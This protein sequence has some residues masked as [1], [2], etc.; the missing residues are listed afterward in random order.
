MSAL[1]SAIQK[2]KVQKQRPLAEHVVFEVTLRGDEGV[3]DVAV[4]KEHAE[5]FEYDWTE[6]S[7]TSR[8]L[9]ALIKRYKAT[10]VDEQE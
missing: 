8:E 10:I 9:N 4:L 5:T 7:G 6:S 2:A 3:Y 1:R